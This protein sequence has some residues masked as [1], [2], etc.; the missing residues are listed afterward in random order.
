MNTETITF[1][2]TQRHLLHLFAHDS[3]EAYARE[4]Q[5]VLMRHFQ[6]LLDEESDHLWDE[7][8]LDQQRLDELRTADLHS[9][10]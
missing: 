1:N 2:P 5:E 6:R 10:V 7:G 9:A 4:V 3:T 8:I